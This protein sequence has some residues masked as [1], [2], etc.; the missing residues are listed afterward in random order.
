MFFKLAYSRVQTQKD[1]TYT[2]FKEFIYD[3][4]PLLLNFEM[5]IYTLYTNIKNTQP[6]MWR[7]LIHGFLVDLKYGVFV[8]IVIKA[9]SSLKQTHFSL[10]N[11]N[12]EQNRHGTDITQN[13]IY[14]I[15]VK[16]N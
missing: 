3:S 4:F 5:Q 12:Y 6:I 11:T 9:I 8:V 1:C 13:G 16:N 7:I 15:S 14:Y 2:D 10:K